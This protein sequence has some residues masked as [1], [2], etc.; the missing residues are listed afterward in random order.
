MVTANAADRLSR[1]ITKGPFEIERQINTSI[2]LTV[3]AGQPSVAIGWLLRHC[4]NSKIPDPI[5]ALLSD[6]RGRSAI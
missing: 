6:F 3:P 1:S 4:P 2:G 5:R